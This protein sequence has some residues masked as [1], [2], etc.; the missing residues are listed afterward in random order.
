[1][2][3]ASIE[4][5]DSEGQNVITLSVRQAEKLFYLSPDIPENSRAFVFCKDD[6]IDV[7]SAIYSPCV[8]KIN[9]A[10]ISFD[11]YVVYNNDAYRAK[12]AIPVEIQYQVLLIR[13]IVTYEEVY[14]AVR[15]LDIEYTNEFNE[16]LS[17]LED[18]RRSTTRRS[19]KISYLTR[20]AL[21]SIKEKL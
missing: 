17:V 12:T 2:S 21:M 18:K 10:I 5:L 20:K 4:L 11:T 1:M 3:S 8:T 7:D 14:N 6:K 19:F 16:I 15:M 13:E 9:P